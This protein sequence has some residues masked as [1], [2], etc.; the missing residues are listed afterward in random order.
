MMMQSLDC[1]KVYV[2]KT[3]VKR[4][5]SNAKVNIEAILYFGEMVTMKGCYNGGITYRLMLYHN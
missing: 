4:L 1:L 3:T 2:N 5:Y